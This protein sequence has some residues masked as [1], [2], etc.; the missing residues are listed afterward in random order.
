M[1]RGVQHHFNDA[2]DVPIRRVN[3]AGIHAE[4]ARNRGANLAGIQSLALDFAALDDVFRKRL[5]DRLLLKGEPKG[6]HVT[7]Q[8][9]LVMADRSQRF[10]QLLLIPTEL[11]PIRELMYVPAVSPHTMR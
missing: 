6:L 1:S 10:G 3:A 11:G 7:D 9:P 2:F 5:K 8:P 4:A